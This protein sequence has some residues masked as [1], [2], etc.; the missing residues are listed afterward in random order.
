MDASRGYHQIWMLPEDEEKTAFITEYGMYCWR[1]MSF[2][3]KNA[4]ATYQ[5]M[6]KTIFEPQIGRNIEIYVDDMLVKRKVR[7]KHLENLG[8][9]FTRI[10]ERIG[11]VPSHSRTDMISARKL[12]AHFESHPI[13]VVTDQLLKRIFTILTL[14]GRMI[15]WAIELS[16]SDITYAP[17]TNVKAHALVD[18]FIECTTPQSL[19]VGRAIELPEPPKIPEW[20]VYVDGARNSK[21]SGAGILI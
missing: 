18:F 4:G 1:V 17:R 16:E 21:G 8:K 11:V 5:R 10:R 19:Q 6:V 7:G 15:T 13:K 2:G 9:T 20:V 12:K 3:L 14:F